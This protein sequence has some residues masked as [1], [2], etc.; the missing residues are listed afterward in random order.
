MTPLEYLLDLMRKPYPSD[1]DAA[2]LAAYDAMKVDAAKAAAPYIHPRL[3]NR[4]DPIKI[5]KLT[6][7]LADQGATVLK[8]LS[9]GEITPSEATAVMQAI[10]SQARV[11]EVD[12]LDRRVKALE[13]K[14]NGK[15]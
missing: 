3:A 5:G 10:A 2:T 9:D 7:G 1:A 4:D 12:E 14:A 15:H 11:L 8:A 13:E 6:G